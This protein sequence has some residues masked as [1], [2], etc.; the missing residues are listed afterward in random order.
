MKEIAKR[1]SHIGPS[2]TLALSQRADELL[3]QGKPIINLTVGE[4]DFDT[5]QHIKD[6]AIKAIQQGLTKYTAVDGMKAL[7]QAILTKLAHENK[8]DYQLKQILV[9][10]GAKHSLF[11]LFQAL[12]NPGDEVIIPAP[13]WVSY[14]DMVKLAEAR[15]VIIETDI[16][17]HFKMSA[18]Q[19]EAAITAQ[20]K[21]LIINSPCNPTGFAYSPSEL[22]AFGDI[23]VKYPEIIVI[24]DDIYEHILWA[25]LPFTNILNA[26][27]ALYERTVVIN[28]VSKAYAMTGWRIGYAAGPDKLIAAMKI[29]QSQSTSNPCSIAQAASI[30]AL[31][32]DQSSI[33]LMTQSFKTRHDLLVKALSSMPGVKCLPADGTFYSFPCIQDVLYQSASL[34]TD[35]E[36]SDYLLNEAHLAVVPGS[37]FGAPGYLRIS[38]ATSTEN[39]EVAMKRMKEAIQKLRK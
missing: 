28:G 20:T 15:P 37:A 2:A 24:T 10:C 16:K 9:S 25:E 31:Q 23:L 26:C 8:L 32:G 11:N 1:V 22:K 4:P 19:L 12:L 38:F 7:K 36:L 17:Q 3:A 27:P 39:L 34:T 35:I 29:I 30:E 21:A 33:R 6:A 13:Y 18:E 14:P 5:P